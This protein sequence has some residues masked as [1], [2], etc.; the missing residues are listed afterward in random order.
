M[1][2]FLLIISAIFVVNAAN[3]QNEYYTSVK[4]GIG[5]VTIYQDDTKLS[6]YFVQNGFEYDGSGLL[7]E[8]SPAVGIDWTVISQ[9]WLHLR[10]EGELGYNYYHE[11]IKL[12]DNHASHRLEIKF[13]QVFFL[14]NGYMDF[15]INKFVP[16]IGLGLGHGWGK[17]TISNKDNGLEDPVDANGQIYALHLGLG[18]KYSDITT[19]DLG[20]RRVYVPAEDDGQYVFDA[21]RLGFRFRI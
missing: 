2:K 1:K 15:K 10:L 7:L 18:Y 14:V 9:G 12:K 5:N 4:M 21:I 6:D 16:Y 13:N 8:I 17:I 3:S 11:N 19:F 20:A